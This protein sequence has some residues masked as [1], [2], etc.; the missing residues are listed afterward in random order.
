MEKR[1]FTL[2]ELLVVVAIITVLAAMLLP[3]MNMVKE[4]A[5]HAVCLSNLRQIAIGHLVFASDNKGHHPFTA[6]DPQRH[7][8]TH[9]GSLRLSADGQGRG[10]RAYADQVWG[11]SPTNSDRTRRPPGKY[12][13]DCGVFFCPAWIRRLRTTWYGYTAYSLRY[14]PGRLD[15]AFVIDGTL[16]GNHRMHYWRIGYNIFAGGDTT[17]TKAPY[18]KYEVPYRV[19][20]KFRRLS[21]SSLPTCWIAADYG[22]TPFLP[23]HI[24]NYQAGFSWPYNVVHVDGHADTHQVDPFR[25]GTSSTIWNTLPGM[26]WMAAGTVPYGNTGYDNGPWGGF[27]KQVTGLDMEEDKRGK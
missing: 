18:N 21:S 9:F 23:H 15:K 14:A 26:Q 6:V 24:G 20:A 17:A 1:G 5:R 2:I 25:A 19:H 12:L 22:R 3:A 27:G 8:G 7:E 10:R 11:L 4:R 16:S 13:S